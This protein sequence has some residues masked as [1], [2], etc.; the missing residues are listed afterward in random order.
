MILW[1]E[2]HGNCWTCFS[3][4]FLPP[5][6]ESLVVQWSSSTE[7]STSQFVCCAKGQEKQR[8]TPEK[9]SHKFTE[10]R[11]KEKRKRRIKRRKLA[12]LN[13]YDPSNNGIGK[14][15]KEKKIEVLWTRKVA[16]AGSVILSNESNVKLLS[17]SLSSNI[18][19][20]IRN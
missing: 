4:H 2:K 13:I 11:G 7:P 8:K 9:H 3:S 16:L 18:K 20:L 6:R 19:P 5:H 14:K 15:K 1:E 17:Q 12:S 10:R